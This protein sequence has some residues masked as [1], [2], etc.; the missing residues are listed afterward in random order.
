[1]LETLGQEKAAK[2][3]EEAVMYVTGN[4]LKSMQAGRMGY[5]TSQIG[6]LVARKVAE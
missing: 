3:V 2:K 5:S 1:M 6:E 4:K